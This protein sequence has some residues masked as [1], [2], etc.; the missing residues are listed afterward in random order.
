[1]DGS[2]FLVQNEYS[3]IEL[4][5]DLIPAGEIEN[6]TATDASTRQIAN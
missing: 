6:A 3:Q 1:V 2:A 4:P 5:Q